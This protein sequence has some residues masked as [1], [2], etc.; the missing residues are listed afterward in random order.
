LVRCQAR[1]G[2]SCLAVFVWASRSAPASGY[3]TDRRWQRCRYRR[4]QRRR[5]R[6]AKSKIANPKSKIRSSRPLRVAVGPKRQ[7]RSGKFR[8]TGLL[9]PT[10]SL[11]ASGV[12]R[13][14]G[15]DRPAPVGG[16]PSDRRRQTSRRDRA[17][18]CQPSAPLGRS[19]ELGS[20]F[21]TFRESHI[22]RSL[23]GPVPLSKAKAAGPVPS[24]S[25]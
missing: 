8:L 23:N 3:P 13:F 11:E 15:A 1:S 4:D 2:T 21:F 20:R 6:S 22:A 12:G 17:S 9:M 18:N 7:A 19:L 16:C 25:L 5:L 10:A 14:V 24:G